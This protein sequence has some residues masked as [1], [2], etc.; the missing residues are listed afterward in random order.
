[1]KMWPQGKVN[2]HLFC[3]KAGLLRILNAYIKG[4]KSIWKDYILYD[5]TCMTFWRRQ[6]Y[7]D[8]KRAMVA[9]VSGERGMNRQSSEEV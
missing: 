5:V 3:K 6:N 2:L 9:M 1:M 7:G 8:N 4:S